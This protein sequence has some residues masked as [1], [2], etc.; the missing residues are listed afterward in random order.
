MGTLET[1]CCG[2]CWRSLIQQRQCRSIKS[3]LFTAIGTTIGVCTCPPTRNIE[4]CTEPSFVLASLVNR[5]SLLVVKHD[6]VNRLVA[7]SVI[8]L[9]SGVC[10]RCKSTARSFSLACSRNMP[11]LLTFIADCVSEPAGCGAMVQPSTWATAVAHT[12]L[13]PRSCASD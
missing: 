7:I 4:P 6:I 9:S 1:S 13:L 8:L 11:P 10:G 2:Y 5:R 3:S 12:A